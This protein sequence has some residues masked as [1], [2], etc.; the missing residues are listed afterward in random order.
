[1]DEDRRRTPSIEACSLGD[2]KLQLV[3]ER[4]LRGI[5]HEASLGVEELMNA[6]NHGYK[7]VAEVLRFITAKPS[8]HFS[9][10]AALW[11]ERVWGMKTQA[12]QYNELM[13]SLKVRDEPWADVE[14]FTAA[15][16]QRH[17]HFR[18]QADSFRCIMPYHRA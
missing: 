9:H 4:S 5:E 1:M 6:K 2:D 12:R 15:D 13:D 11:M 16:G 7:G 18:T 3:T 10:A 17:Y 8:Y 14:K